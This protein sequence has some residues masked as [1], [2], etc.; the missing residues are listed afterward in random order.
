MR[1]I[2]DYYSLSVGADVGEMRLHVC[3]SVGVCEFYM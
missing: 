3:M 2:L 1:K